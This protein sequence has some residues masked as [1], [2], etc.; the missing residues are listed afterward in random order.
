MATENFGLS[1]SN[2]NKDLMDE[3]QN[4]EKEGE[5]KDNGSV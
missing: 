1:R 3:I 5:E 4:I 2:M